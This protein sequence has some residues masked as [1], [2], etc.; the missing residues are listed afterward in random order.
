[1]SKAG[2]YKSIDQHD[3]TEMVV[4]DAE[5]VNDDAPSTAKDPYF[6][7]STI[8]E[9]DQPQGNMVARGA[10]ALCGLTGCLVGGPFL[11]I[12]AAIGGAYS[13]THHKGPVGD[14]SRAIGEVALAASAKAKEHHVREKT[15]KAAKTVVKGLKESIRGKSSVSNASQAPNAEVL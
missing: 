2:I 11:A 9:D 7:D 15:G 12:L 4:V 14:A 8:E 5:R 1:M 10:A 13:A 6:D 3:E